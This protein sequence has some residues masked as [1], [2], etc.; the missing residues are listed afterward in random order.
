MSHTLGSGPVGV[1]LAATLAGWALLSTPDA[2]AGV[3]FAAVLLLGVL[4][5]LGGYAL[6]RWRATA[7]GVALPVGVGAAFVA[8]LPGS[9]DAS[10]AAPPLGYANANAA[11]LTI[12]T[13]AALLA[14][15]HV[16]D[17]SRT[18]WIVAAVALSAVSFGSASRAGLASCL[19]LL[20][21]WPRLRSLGV[22]TWRWLSAA[23]LV[24]AVAVTVLV[25]ATGSDSDRSMVAARAVPTLVD[26]TF[27]GTRA[28]LW[29]D[30][31][32]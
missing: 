21:L 29:G 2:P 9:L 6:A 27:S 10:A 14:A 13:A 4:G 28:A 8:G 25:G 11:L 5:T 3:E 23:V 32:D 7:V 20:A 24:G 30:A 26:D 15:G 16:K 12:A 17:R 1:L 22:G 18:W 19:L 31:L